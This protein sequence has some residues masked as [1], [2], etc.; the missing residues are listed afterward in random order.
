MIP[1]RA[2]FTRLLAALTPVLLLW[3]FVG[4]VAVCAAHAEE[5]RG[6]DVVA[7]S[8]EVS[9][10]HCSEPCPVNEG[11]FLVPAKRFAPE[12]QAVNAQP[13]PAPDSQE[14]PRASSPPG[15][16]TETLKPPEPIFRRLRTLRI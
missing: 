7:V 14:P 12:R 9:D 15:R 5:G 13:D 10:A 11:F 16:R 2:P 4:C 6:E 8:V 3:A 1:P